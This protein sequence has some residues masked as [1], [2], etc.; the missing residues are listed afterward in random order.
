MNYLLLTL[1]LST[2]FNV[3]V[4]VFNLRQLVFIRKF[5]TESQEQDLQQSQQEA[6][7]IHN[8]LNNRL[9]DLQ[10]RKYALQRGT[11]RR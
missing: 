3:V 10:S 8:I 1:F 4:S 2:V 5:I 6:Q 11:K 9:L 7:D